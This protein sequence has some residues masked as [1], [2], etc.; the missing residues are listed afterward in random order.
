MRHLILGG[1]GTVGS[2]VVN[3]LLA[4]GEKDVR[5]LTR[6]AEKAQ[7]VPKGVTAVV[8][9]LADPGTYPSIFRDFDTLFLLNLV[10]PAELQE[11][12]AGVNEAQRAKAK[13]IVYLSVHDAEKGMTIPHFAAKVAIEAAI[14]DTG[15]PYTVIRPNNFHQN[16][17]WFK[18]AILQYGVYP[19]PIGEIGLSRVDVRDIAE[20][21]AN[22]LT[23]SGH[24]NRYYALVGPDVL[25]GQDC[26]K[27]WS[28][29]LGRTIKYGGND[30][31]AWAKQMGAYMPAWGIYDF[32]LMYEMFQSKGLKA[33][34][35]Q[36]KECE[37][38]VGHAPRSY[39]D[40]VRET[41]AAW[42]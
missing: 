8:G 38:I 2:A 39:R 7:K 9:D 12:L 28:D 19:Q 10:T 24:E 29:A 20:A 6:S 14:K 32:R 16:D 1:T 22:A 3:E 17:S 23:R 27:H 5:V 31:D 26:A 35:A 34:A 30:M 4:R 40:Y 15:I 25:S 13:R 33:T 36:L 37:T 42:K 41:A 21:S 11:G 18:D